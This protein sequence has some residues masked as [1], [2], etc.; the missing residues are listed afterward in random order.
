MMTDMLT[1]H[2]E[3]TALYVN[4]YSFEEYLD[5]LRHGHPELYDL[6]SYERCC[7]AERH[8]A[9]MNMISREFE[10]EKV[11]GRGFAYN[12]AQKSADNRKV[13]MTK[14]LECFGSSFDVPGQ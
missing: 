13:G 7:D 11:G 5:Y 6:L 1:A 14:L 9:Q 8:I 3:R 2:T 10:D 4:G 12:V